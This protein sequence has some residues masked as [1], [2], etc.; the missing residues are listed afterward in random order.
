MIIG[1]LLAAGGARRF[2]SQK[3]VAEI[4]G[5]PIVRC[6]ADSLSQAT[7]GVIMVVGSEAGAVTAKRGQ[8]QAQLDAAPGSCACGYGVG[9]VAAG[10]G[11]S[12]HMR[13]SL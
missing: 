6:A 4:N 13:P 10:S 11:Q 9:G 5:V 1:L 3:L 7:D 2:G 8:K 12:S